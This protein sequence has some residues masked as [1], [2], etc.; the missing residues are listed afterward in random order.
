M[1]IINSQPSLEHTVQ[2]LRT[3]IK[4]AMSHN[5]RRVDAEHTHVGA[6]LNGIDVNAT[7]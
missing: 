4:K 3:T 7:R 1:N 5:I 6:H 2:S